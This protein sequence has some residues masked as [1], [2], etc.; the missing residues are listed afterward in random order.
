MALGLTDPDTGAT[1]AFQDTDPPH[2]AG[3]A[4]VDPATTSG[5]VPFTREALERGFSGDKRRLRRF[6][7]E[8]R[9]GLPAD[10]VIG[11][12]GS[13]VVGH[14][15]ESGAPF[16]AAGPGTSDLDIVVIG[17][18]AKALWVP[19]A[20]LAGGL[21]TLPLCDKDPWV[22]PDL[23]KARRRAQVIAGRPVSIQAMPGWFLGL[24]SLVQ[25]TP[26]TILSNPA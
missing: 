7:A 11:L 4:P 20:Q 22:A 10:T 15:Y 21:N 16:D 14:A 12:R 9:R 1:A 24:R 3:A 13:A 25:G 8:L 19:E 2:E 26:Y 5:E 18:E 17:D 6:L 23:D